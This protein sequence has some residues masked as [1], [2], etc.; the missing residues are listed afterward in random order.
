MDVEGIAAHQHDVRRFDRHVGSGADCNADIG[1]RQS[2][3]VVDPVANHGHTFALLLQLS[4]IRRFLRGEHFGK[5]SLDTELARHRFCGAPAVAAHHDRFDPRRV[6]PPNRLARGRFD[7][8]G[9]GQ[10]GR[11]LAIDGHQDR[12]PSQTGQLVDL[13]EK[14]VDRNTAIPHQPGIAEQHGL[15]IDHGFDAMPRDRLEGG[16]IGNRQSTRARAIDDGLR[17]R[18][19]GPDFGGSSQTQD[20]VISETRLREHI[21]QAWLS[22]GQGAGLVQHDHLHPGDTLE[23]GRVLDEDVVPRGDT[24]SHRHRSR[25]RQTQRIRAGDDDGRDRECQR[26]DEPNTPEQTPGNEGQ[27][28]GAHRQDHQILRGLVGQTL[29][30]RL[31]VLRVLHHGHDLGERGIRPHFGCHDSQGSRLVDR[32][33]NHLVARP[34]LHRQALP[35]DQRLI[36]AGRTR[37]HLAIDRNLL[38]GPHEHD[39]AGHNLCR[40]NLDFLPTA[41]DRRGRRHQIEERAQRIG[42]AAAALHLHPVTE[43]HEGHQHRGSFEEDIFLTQRHEHDAGSIRG[44]DAGGDEHAH[45]ELAGTQGMVG[46][47]KKDPTSPEHD[48]S[49]QQEHDPLGRNRSGQVDAEEI[50]SQR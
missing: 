24:G 37:A 16:R 4:D 15:P 34:F 45:V 32:T 39:I 18:M 23:G 21:G 35:G 11:R 46:A 47:G 33:A 29:A 40:R 7:G 14:A 43:E 3:R 49:G 41:H 36:D 19:L 13:R 42:G 48:R 50:T 27:H 44:Q 8:V 9:N 20:L 1:L 17:Q 38:A 25:S 10:D 6:E 2:R 30:G 26:G 22:F 12:G 28:P 31:R 5:H